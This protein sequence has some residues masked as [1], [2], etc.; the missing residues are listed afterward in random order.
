[1]RLLLA[2]ILAAGSALAQPAPLAGLK[3][4]AVF[5]VY[6]NEDPVITA[7]C[8]WQADGSLEVEAVI[9]MAGQ[10]V[11]SKDTIVVDKDGLWTKLV[12]TSPAGT[13]T[14]VREGSTARRTFKEKTE[15]IDVKPAPACSATTCRC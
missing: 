6:V 13:V 4:D 11:T 10:R 12:Q 15:I 3:D 8:K 14:T 9:A 7:T 2:F 1:M 5:R